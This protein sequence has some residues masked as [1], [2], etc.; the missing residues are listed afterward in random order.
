MRHVCSMPGIIDL[1]KW[2]PGEILKALNTYQRSSIKAD[3]GV[4]NVKNYV[5]SSVQAVN[6]RTVVYSTIKTVKVAEVATSSSHTTVKVEQGHLKGIQE[7]ANK[8][9]ANIH[10]LKT[11]AKTVT[12]AK[13]A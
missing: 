7:Q 9:K 6:D 13:I 3:A 8:E 10:T 11:R 1:I 5:Q 4:G 12:P 2:K